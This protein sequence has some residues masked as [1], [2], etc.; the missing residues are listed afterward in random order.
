[1]IFYTISGSIYELDRDKN[2]I[3]RLEGVENPT[4]RQG[5]DGE[6]KTFEHCNEVR[7]GYSVLIQW[8]GIR[9]TLTSPVKT[10]SSPSNT[11]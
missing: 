9:S 3:R 6:W 2:R 4:P 10:I 11:N 8:E 5:A 7:E 1:M